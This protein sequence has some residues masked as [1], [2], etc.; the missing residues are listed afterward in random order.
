MPGLVVLQQRQPGTRRVSR[1][2]LPRAAELLCTAQLRRLC[3]FNLLVATFLSGPSQSLLPRH[4]GTSLLGLMM[5]HWV[6]SSIPTITMG[7]P[8]RSPDFT[9]TGALPSQQRQKGTEPGLPKGFSS[10]LEPPLMF[11]HSPAEAQAVPLGREQHLL[12]DRK[13]KELIQPLPMVSW[14]AKPEDS[15]LTPQSV[16]DGPIQPCQPGQGPTARDTAGSWAGV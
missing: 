12:H 6:F 7:F 13:E 15:C 2:S 9:C 3:A 1:H 11:R 8:F 16:M 5:Q 10:Y 14:P 4:V